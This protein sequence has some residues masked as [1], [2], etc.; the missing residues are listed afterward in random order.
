MSIEETGVD[1]KSRYVSV[2]N[3]RTHFLEAG[4]GRP[5]V[6]LHSGEFG[7]CAE[8]SWEFVIPKL[9]ERYHVIAPDWLG[10]GRTDKLHDFNETPARRLAHLRRFLEV[11]GI[12]APHVVGNSMGGSLFARGVAA[13]PNAYSL[14]SLT[15]ISAGGFAPD[16]EH[17]RVLLAYDCT[18]EAMRALIRAMFHDPRWAE[19]E[20][21]VERRYQL[22]LLPGAWECTAAA[23]F[24]NPAAPQRERFGQPDNT[25]YEKIEVPVLI[26]AGADDKLRLPGYAQ[27]L[28]AKF[29]LA[30]LHV[31]DACGHCPNIERAADVNRILLDFF[32]RLDGATS[33]TV[34]AAS[35]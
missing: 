15:L 27:E 34:A 8:I 30:E 17:R 12:E 18:R 11:L 13:E 19:D 24:K 28:A 31:L 6:L 29:R 1:V 21:Y 14:R 20:A 33:K 9:A 4:Q 22:S 7:G 3:I 2:D 10:F 23:R 25:P 26:I 32:G 5:V 16:N 35:R